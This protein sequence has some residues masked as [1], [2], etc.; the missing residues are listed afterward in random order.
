MKIVQYVFKK[1]SKYLLKKYM[2]CSASGTTGRAEVKNV[3]T[4]SINKSRIKCR[5]CNVNATPVYELY[6][7]DQRAVFS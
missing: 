7:P 1:F 5:S 2:K 6:V 4:I 3:A